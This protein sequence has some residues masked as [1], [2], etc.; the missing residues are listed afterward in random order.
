[1]FAPVST[2]SLPGLTGSL[3]SDWR[4]YVPFS[5]EEL[6]SRN[7]LY[8]TGEYLSKLDSNLLGGGLLNLNV[9]GWMGVVR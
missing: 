8:S 7:R 1:M 2:S 6:D 5:V 4:V 9:L 3:D